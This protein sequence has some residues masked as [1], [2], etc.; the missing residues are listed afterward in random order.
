MKPTVM[1]AEDDRLL[2]QLLSIRLRKAGFDVVAAFDSMQSFMLAVRATPAA[3][4]L[5]IS[6]PGG[7]GIEILKKLKLSS[8]TSHIP[9]LVLSGSADPGMSE[10]VKALGAEEFFAKPPDLDLLEAALG[11]ILNLP[12]VPIQPRVMRAS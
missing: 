7:S 2:S 12:A 3:I 8:K 6:M 10:T 9:V 5:D 11:R 4:L 1:I